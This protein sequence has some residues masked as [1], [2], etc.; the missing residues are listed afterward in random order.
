MAENSRKGDLYKD[1]IGRL[2]FVAAII[3]PRSGGNKKSAMLIAKDDG[4]ERL[5]R[6]SNLTKPLWTKVTYPRCHYQ[7]VACSGN[8]G[9]QPGMAGTS[10]SSPKQTLTRAASGSFA[11]QPGKMVARWVVKLASGIRAI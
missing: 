9:S 4:E 1:Q 3:S 7:N 6:F 10:D 2:W 5:V 8:S 11:L